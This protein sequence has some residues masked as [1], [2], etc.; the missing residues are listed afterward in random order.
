MIGDGND[1]CV[2]CGI[3]KDQNGNCPNCRVR[4][5]T[6]EEIEQEYPEFRSRIPEEYRQYLAKDVRE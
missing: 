2:I 6:V 4:A 1:Y 3:H 5:M